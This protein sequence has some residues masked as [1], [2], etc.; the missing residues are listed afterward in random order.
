MRATDNKQYS[1]ARIA[2]L[3]NAELVGA[4]GSGDVVVSGIAPLHSA[5]PG[6]ITFLSK[7]A[8][9]KYLSSTTAAAVIVS[10]K[11]T[12]SCPRPLLKVANPYLAYA[13]LSALFDTSAQREPGI[14]PSAVVDN[15]ARVAASACVGPNV[16]IE[17]H[18]QVGEDTI[19]DAGTVI[20]AG[21]VVG[22]QC[23]FHRNVTLY[24]GI[25]I[26]DRVKIHSGT[27]I[28]SDGFGYAPKP[29]GGWQKIHQLGRVVIGNDVEIGAC[30][31]ID[32]G[33]LEDT[34]IEDGVII[35]NQV[36]I[37]HNVHIG[38]NTAIA[39]CVGIAGSTRIGAN[40]TIAGASGVVG[41]ITIADNVHIT[42]MSMVTHSIE[43]AGSYSSGTGVTTTAEWRKNAVRFTQLDSMARRLRD[44]ERQQRSDDET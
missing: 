44:L 13:E 37:A 10:I 30:T 6:Q 32:R 33:A 22:K 41:H 25:K 19:I 7:P 43:Q 23:H 3:L 36:H 34:V 9:E 17:A 4:A 16:V 21:S 12:T 15:T 38:K 27:T 18:V 29:G 24:H 35:D 42:G 40:C 39:G 28:G 14:H 2:G 20:G 8:F 5:G 11:S 26:G 31:A 1:L